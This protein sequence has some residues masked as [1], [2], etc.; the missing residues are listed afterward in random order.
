[1]RAVDVLEVLHVAEQRDG[2]Q[3]LAQTHFVSLTK[4]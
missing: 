4:N 3:R 1:V 2:L